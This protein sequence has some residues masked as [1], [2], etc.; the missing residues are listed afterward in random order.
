MET[1]AGGG[2]CRAEGAGLHWCALEAEGK[3]ENGW[4]GLLG[5]PRMVGKGF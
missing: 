2:G 5:K 4:E 3:Y 1:S